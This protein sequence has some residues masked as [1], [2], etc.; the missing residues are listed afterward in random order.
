VL[1]ELGIHL[2]AR[3]RLVDRHAVVLQRRTHVVRVE[4]FRGVEDAKV[5]VHFCSTP[6]KV[7]VQ[8]DTKKPAEAGCEIA[9]Q[10]VLLL[11]V[12]DVKAS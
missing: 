5:L 11:L 1:R 4:G 8:L 7:A 12:G 3:S 9:L 2:L 6:I 10:V